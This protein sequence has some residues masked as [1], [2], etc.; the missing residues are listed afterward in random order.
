M[1]KKIPLN[2]KN[3][4]LSRIISYIASIYGHP[5]DAI[6]QYVENSSVS[7]LNNPIKI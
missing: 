1:A 5:R 4:N 3:G 2:V 7:L 6:E